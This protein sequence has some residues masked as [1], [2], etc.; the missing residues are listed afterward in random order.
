MSEFSHRSMDRLIRKAG[1]E[2]VS[3]DASLELNAVLETLGKKIAEEAIRKAKQEGVKTIKRR[4]I[5]KAAEEVNP[6]QKG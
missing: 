6:L 2:R 1:N 4:H 5:K 3:K